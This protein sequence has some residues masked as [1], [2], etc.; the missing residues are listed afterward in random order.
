MFGKLGAKCPNSKTVLQIK[1]GK[2]IAKFSGCHEAGRNTNIM[3]QHI[4][5]CCRKERK[6]AGGF[7]WQYL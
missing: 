2:I 5:M 7:E 4:A 6:H 1:N 3:Y